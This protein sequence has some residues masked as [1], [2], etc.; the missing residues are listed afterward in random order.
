MYLTVAATNPGQ[1]FISVM[2]STNVG[3]YDLYATPVLNN[4]TWTCIATG[5]LLQTN[6]MVN[7][8]GYPAE[9]YRAIWDTN[10]IPYWMLADPNNPA[11][12]ALTVFIDCPTNGAVLQ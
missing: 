4:P 5:A 12:G 10:A 6:F 11:T 8:P 2:N 9:F 1:L 3:T 7:I